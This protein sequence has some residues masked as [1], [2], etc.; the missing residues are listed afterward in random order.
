MNKNYKSNMGHVQGIQGL[1]TYKVYQSYAKGRLRVWS[2]S[3]YG[4]NIFIFYSFQKLKN[5]IK[6]PKLLFFINY[7][8]QKI[9]NFII[10][11]I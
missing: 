7:F 9:I 10:F 2:P 8:F 5:Y 1:Y 3:I 6:Y 11:F 4:Q